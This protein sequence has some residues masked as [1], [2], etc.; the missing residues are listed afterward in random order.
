MSSITVNLISYR[1]IVDLVDGLSRSD[2]NT[3]GRMN[4]HQAINFLIYHIQVA[5]G[6]IEVKSKPRLWDRTVGKHMHLYWRYSGA[7]NSTIERKF[8]GKEFISSGFA[9]DKSILLAKLK[10]YIMQPEESGQ[11]CHPVYGY[12]AKEEYVLLILRMI[13]FYLK[14]FSPAESIVQ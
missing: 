5:L 4:V 14:P 9:T 7:H 13:D 12:L 11:H 6:E 10:K 1:K 8:T 3:S 2:Y